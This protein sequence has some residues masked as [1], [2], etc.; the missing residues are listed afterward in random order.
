MTPGGR[1]AAGAYLHFVKICELAKVFKKYVL[2]TFLFSSAY[3]IRTWQQ[4]RWNLATL[5]IIP[6]I[7][8]GAML[9]IQK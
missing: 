5:R 1:K 9:K 6:T 8:R 3:A 7:E 4:V 2:F